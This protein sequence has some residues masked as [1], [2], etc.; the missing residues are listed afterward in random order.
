MPQPVI[1]LHLTTHTATVCNIHAPLKE[2]LNWDLFLCQDW[3]GMAEE[4]P[5]PPAPANHLKKPLSHVGT[6]GCRL[7]H[8]HQ[9]LIRAVSG[10]L[11]TDQQEEVAGQWFP[12]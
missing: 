12:D 10:P 8:P 4:F 3:K 1:R 11:V 2:N 7:G 5:L 6:L 9:S